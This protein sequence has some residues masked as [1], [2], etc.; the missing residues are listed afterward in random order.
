[1]AGNRSFKDYVADRFY[2][3]IFSAIQTY[4]TD[5]CEDLDLRLYRVRNI[6]GIELSDVEVKFV[7]V[8]DLPDMK[9]EFDVAVEAEFEVRESD[10]HYDE[11]ENCRQWFMLEC[12]EI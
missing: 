1:M 12:Q 4:A 11:S 10:Y 3:E 8:N 7:S 2:N 9:I 5:N 6:G